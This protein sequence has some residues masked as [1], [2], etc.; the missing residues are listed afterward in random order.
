M[1]A[2]ASLCL[3]DERVFQFVDHNGYVKLSCVCVYSFLHQLLLH[4]F[5]LLFFSLWT[6]SHH[7]MKPAFREP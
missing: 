5:T 3:L 6:I 1:N 7:S 4:H 2:D